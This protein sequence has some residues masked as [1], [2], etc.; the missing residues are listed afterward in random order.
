MEQEK[1]TLKV[2]T[3]REEKKLLEEYNVLNQANNSRWSDTLLVDSIMIPS[4]LLTI[5]WALIERN[6]LG[7]IDIAGFRI[8]LAGVLPILAL[9]L[10]FIAYMTHLST[11]KLDDFYIKRIEKIEDLLK[12]SG[13]TFIHNKVREKKW[14][15]IRLKSYHVFFW[16]LI[17]SY[18][19]FTIFLF[20]GTLIN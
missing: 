10:I 5:S 9:T 15:K 12:I 8:P 13:H 16:I 20:A 14:W 3:E 18:I 17:I 2:L 1:D 11:S 4:S 7:W 19:L 6:T